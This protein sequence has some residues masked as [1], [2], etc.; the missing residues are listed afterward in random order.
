MEEMNF[1]QLGLTEPMLKAVAKMGFLEPTTVQREV[2]PAMRAGQDIM[3]KAPTGTGKTLAF[4]IPILER[5]DPGSS[6]VQA[7]V[8]APTRE[9]AIQID[10]E[11]KKL[12]AFL[13]GI[14]SIVLY[15]GQNIENQIKALQRL[16]PQVVV[17]TP[18]RLEDHLRRRTVNL[19]QVSIAVLDE[20]D[21]MLDMGFIHEVR[22]ILDGLKN[23]KQLALLSATMSREVMDISWIYQ[24]D[25]LEVTVQPKQQDLPPIKQY[26]I[27]TPGDKMDEIAYLL[28]RE[29][30]ERVLV[31]CNTKTMCQR[32][33]IFFYQRGY[34]ADSIHGDATQKQRELTME[35]F[36]SGELRM[37]VATDVAARG[38]DIQGVDAVFN[39]DIPNENESYLHRIGRTGRAQKPGVAYT[40][41]T[42]F[43]GLRM[44]ELARMTRSAI[45]PLEPHCKEKT[46]WSFSAK[47]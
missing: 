14:H 15:G 32:V 3:A 45:E 23:R 33:A 46:F 16:K 24:R 40:L 47:K 28:D 12:C 18:G 9:L 11:F 30:Y 4:A 42:R 10:E 34:S 2:I 44:R 26:S 29:Q 41:L 22:R 31:F 27:E 36:R 39:Y 7:L 38:L 6:A 1:V 20:A 35:R 43:E 5:V 19:S 25:P 13:P 21:R 17:A 8:L 37:L